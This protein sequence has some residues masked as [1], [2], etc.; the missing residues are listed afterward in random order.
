MAKERGWWKISFTTTPSTTDLEHIATLIKQG[1]VEG[2]I[3]E[4]EQ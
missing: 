2:E 1:N 3:V 4:D